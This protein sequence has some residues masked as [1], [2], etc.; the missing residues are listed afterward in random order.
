M[1]TTIVNQ[2][3]ELLMPPIRSDVPLTR[4]HIQILQ[5]QLR[6]L[7][8]PQ[9]D[10][11]P[12]ALIYCLSNI[13][14]R[15]RK[16]RSILPNALNREISRY[17]SIPDAKKYLVG[18]DLPSAQITDQIAKR[19]EQRIKEYQKLIREE[20]YSSWEELI[21]EEYKKGRTIQELIPFITAQNIP[22]DRTGLWRDLIWEEYNKG[23]K[24]QQLL[25]FITVQ[26]IPNEFRRSFLWSDL[27]KEE[28][29]K[30]RMSFE[31][32]IPFMTA[33][34]I[35]D[36]D[37]R[38]FIW[39]HLIM[40]EHKKGRMSFQQLE[41]FITAQNIPDEEIRSELENF[42]YSSTFQNKKRGKRKGSKKRSKK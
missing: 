15:R 18:I 6:L 34:N 13:V 37:N 41:P 14:I 27:L 35:P 25:R 21:R 8:A 23:R 22:F 7:L 38:S 32:S 40:E 1:T 39:N 30:G 26:N 11:V 20:K 3:V 17:L 19:W 42:L 33:Q 5:D 36:E 31:E 10:L 4:T 29:N 9:M 12:D 24:F 2:I 16:Q 28:Y